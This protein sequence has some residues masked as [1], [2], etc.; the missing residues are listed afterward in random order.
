MKERKKLFIFSGAFI[1]LLILYLAFFQED[2]K[3][4]D[5]SEDYVLD[6]DKPYGTWLITELLK[7]YDTE[8]KFTIPSTPVDRSL[9][10][11][12]KNSNYVFI[13]EEIF[14]DNAA[15]DSLVSYVHRGNNAFIFTRSYPKEIIKRTRSV[16]DIDS[17]FHSYSFFYGDSA[18]TWIEVEKEEKRE[19]Y[20]IPYRSRFKSSSYDWN[21]FDGGF[22]AH[23]YKALGY[24]SAY[25]ENEMINEVNFY[26]IDYG[27]GSFYF[28]TQPVI[29][30]NIVLKEDEVLTYVRRPR[31]RR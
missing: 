30:T 15:A 1:G 5:W 7:E 22:N 8:R 17:S 27:K 6:K 23:D 25:N 28:H 18:E 2:S 9:K 31:S 19:Y 26:K 21:F 24:F 16:F 20:S 13:G 3:R 14:L 4:F 10:N 12:E 11:W 29:F